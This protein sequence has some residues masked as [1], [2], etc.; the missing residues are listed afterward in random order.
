VRLGLRC[1]LAESRMI[2]VFLVELAFTI[3]R[4]VGRNT[5]NEALTGTIVGTVV[6]LAVNF[7]SLLRKS[8]AREGRRSGTPSE[9]L[10]D[11]PRRVVG[12]T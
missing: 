9:T 10:R 3:L 11:P 1:D 6:G 7:Q 12:H 5:R 8:F 4:R 2:P